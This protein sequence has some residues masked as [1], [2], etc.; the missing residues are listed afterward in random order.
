MKLTPS[1]L[2]ETLMGEAFPLWAEILEQDRKDTQARL[3]GRLYLTCT[4]AR[5]GCRGCYNL[6]KTAKELGIDFRQP[7]PSRPKLDP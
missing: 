5:G 3:I 7:A 2:A 6:K 1:D 4:C